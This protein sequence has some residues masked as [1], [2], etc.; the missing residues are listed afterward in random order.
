VVETKTVYCAAPYDGD[1]ESWMLP[2][3]EVAESPV[4]GAGM[5]S[6]LAIADRAPTPAMFEAVTA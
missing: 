5:V 4:G 1:Q 6:A 3:P 2:V